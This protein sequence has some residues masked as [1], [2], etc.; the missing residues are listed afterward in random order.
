[1]ALPN[2]PT[3]TKELSSIA[4]QWLAATGVKTNAAYTKE[5]I[6]THPDY[7]AMTAITDF[8]ESG[9]MAY[10]AV[11]ADA[12]YI[13]EFNYPLIAHIKQPGNEYL[14]LINDASVWD[15]E[16]VLLKTGAA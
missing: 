15:K 11:L 5:A 4:Q 8:L 16:K 14:H 1:M 3:E 10:D 7:P 9:G 12:S 6:T 2:K 13:H